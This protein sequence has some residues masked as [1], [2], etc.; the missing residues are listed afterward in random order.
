MTDDVPPLRLPRGKTPRR[1]AVAKAKAAADV[2]AEAA[3]VKRDEAPPPPPTGRWGRDVLGE[4]FEAR[5]FPQPDDDEGAVVTTLIR[6]RPGRAPLPRR[7]RFAVLYVHGWADYFIQT[8]LAQFWTER[9]AVFYAVDLRKSGRSIRPHQTP[10]FVESL[11]EYDEDLDLAVDVI[12]NVHGAAVPILLVAHS[13]GGL[14]TALWTKR[15]PGTF[16]G[17]V[18][19]SPFLE[20]HGSSLAR[21]ISHP[22]VTQVA[23]RQSRWPVPIAAPTFYDRTINEHEDGEWTI[24]PTWRPVPT[25]PIRPG[26]VNAVMSGHKRLGS[27]PELDIPIL[28]MTS[29]RTVIGSRWREE[30]RTADVVID[31]KQVWRRVPD[32]G[33]TVTLAKIQ[34]AIHDVLLSPHPV[35]DHAYEQI[36]RWFHGYIEPDLPPAPHITGS[37]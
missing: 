22:V 33:R 7:P 36:D 6:H 14:T 32:L 8:E 34:D 3:P 25:H 12:R 37:R 2:A 24:E 27:R 16:L 4:D 1:K 9:G 30:M 23:R 26:W 5:T 17:I 20:M 19:N 35:R 11:E 10:C 15:H 31:V 21:A 29:H 13:Q 28:V 18:M